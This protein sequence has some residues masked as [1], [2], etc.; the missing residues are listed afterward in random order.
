MVKITKSNFRQTGSARWRDRES[1]QRSDGKMVL[2]LYSSASTFHVCIHLDFSLNT[3][4]SSSFAF[5][6][7]FFKRGNCISWHICSWTSQSEFPVQGCCWSL[8]FPLHSL[9]GFALR[10]HQ[11]PRGGHGQAHRWVRQPELGGGERFWGGLK[12]LR[13]LSVLLEGADGWGPGPLATRSGA[14]DHGLGGR[15]PG[16]RAARARGGERVGFNKLGFGSLGILP[17]WTNDTE[18]KTY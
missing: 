1:A 8:I 15:G 13:G 4:N 18:I 10:R 14:V 2:S 12:E 11:D 5:F 9:K 16:A 7:F 17:K 3:I 6:F